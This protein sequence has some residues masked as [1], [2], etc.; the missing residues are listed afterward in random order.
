MDKEKILEN[1]ELM[2]SEVEWEF[3]QEYAVTYTHK[4]FF[5]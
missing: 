2:R 1:I 3:T 4:F 5:I